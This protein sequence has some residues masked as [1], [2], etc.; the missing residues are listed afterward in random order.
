MRSVISAANPV[1]IAAVVAQQFEVGRRIADAGLV[2]IIE[3]ETTITAL[4][5]AASEALLKDALAGLDAWARR[6]ARHVQGVDP[7]G[8]RVLVRPDRPPEGAPAS[9]RCRGFSQADADVRGSSATPG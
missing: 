9:S 1:G 7:G 8:G 5:R 2:P 6:P 3:P 4:D